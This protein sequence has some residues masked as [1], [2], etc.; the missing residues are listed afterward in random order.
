MAAGGAGSLETPPRLVHL[1][2]FIFVFYA[3]ISA[4]RSEVTSC[5][6]GSQ[7]NYPRCCQ[8]HV[9]SLLRRTASGDS[10]QNPRRC[11]ALFSDRAGRELTVN[12][13]ATGAGAFKT[14]R[15]FARQQLSGV[16]GA[17]PVFHRLDVPGLW[18]TGDKMT[19]LF[20]TYGH[21]LLRCAISRLTHDSSLVGIDRGDTSD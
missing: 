5:P 18:G 4:P 12:L 16:G 7:L 20:R 21:V 11:S 10:S 19:I 3:L 8:A 9:A 15:G 6:A 14:A 13:S 1:S 17:L 2:I